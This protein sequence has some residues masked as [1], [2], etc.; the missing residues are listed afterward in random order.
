MTF[1]LDLRLTY[2]YPPY[3]ILLFIKI[4]QHFII[5]SE[6]KKYRL[7]NAMFNE[8]PEARANFVIIKI[9]LMLQFNLYYNFI[10][11]VQH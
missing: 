7:H 8:S 2:I 5:K 3:E 10:I 1:A 9:R 6:I 4:P 11:I